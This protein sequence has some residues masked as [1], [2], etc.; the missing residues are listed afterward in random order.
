MYVVISSFVYDSELSICKKIN[1]KQYECRDIA[2]RSRGC[3][4]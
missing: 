1:Q 2:E 4:S 3:T